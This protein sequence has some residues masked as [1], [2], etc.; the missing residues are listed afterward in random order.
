MLLHTVWMRDV[1]CGKSRLL[2]VL[3]Y[4]VDHGVRQWAVNTYHSG[5]VALEVARA[6]SHL[7]QV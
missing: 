4:A 1:R 2:L 7:F 6:E 3:A 5:Q